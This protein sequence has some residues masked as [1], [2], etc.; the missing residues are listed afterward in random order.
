MTMARYLKRAI[1]DGSLQQLRG[2]RQRALQERRARSRSTAIDTHLRRPRLTPFGGLYTVVDIGTNADEFVPEGAQGH[3]R[4]RGARGGFGA[5]LTNGVR[6]SFGPL[7]IDTGPHRRGPGA[8]RRVDARLSGPNRG[9]PRQ[10]GRKAHNRA[11]ADETRRAG[12]GRPR[13]N[14][15]A[16]RAA[17]QAPGRRARPTF[18]K[19]VAPIFFA[20]C[21]TCH[22]PGEIAPMSLLTY[23]DARRGRASIADAGR[24]TA[25]C[26]RGTPTR[27][28]GHFANERRLTAAQKATIARVG[29]GRRA[30]RRRRRI[31][32]RRR[33]HRRAGT[34]A[35]P[36]PC[37]RCRRTIRFP[38]TARSRTS[39]SR[40]R[41]TSRGPLDQAWEVRPGNPRGRAPRDRLRA[42]AAEVP[43]RRARPQAGAPARPAAAAAAS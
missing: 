16:D 15:S 24:K 35:S 42:P 13:P 5:S 19:D 41:P 2:R 40:C 9:V 31:C 20:H 29:R 30:G 17:A 36:T 6:I 22:R 33:L 28:Y 32:R 21:T 11:H 27:P 25:R 37:S 26:R 18:T 39:T 12:R 38:P 34:S 23:K 43:T 10:P 7:V 4:A 1:A 8:A 3:R 14:S